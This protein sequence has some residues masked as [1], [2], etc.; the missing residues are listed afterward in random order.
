MWEVCAHYCAFL[1]KISLLLAPLDATQICNAQALLDFVDLPDTKIAIVV[2][3]QGCQQ[4]MVD[5]IQ[6]N[7]AVVI[8]IICT[9]ALLQVYMYGL[10]IM[11]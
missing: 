7:M 9:F 8:A 5:K 6:V 11:D 10:H 3:V 4:S 2:N 1:K